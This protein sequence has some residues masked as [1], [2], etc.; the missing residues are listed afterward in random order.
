M[1]YL[2]K[3]FF[4]TAVAVSL[5]VFEQECWATRN[6]NIKRLNMCVIN[7]FDKPIEIG[8]VKSN[9]DLECLSADAVPEEIWAWH[10]DVPVGRAIEF[11]YCSI[12]GASEDS[13][14]VIVPY[15]SDGR[16]KSFKVFYKDFPRGCTEGGL[17]CPVIARGNVIDVVDFTSTS[18]YNVLH[19]YSLLFFVRVGEKEFV[20]NNRVTPKWV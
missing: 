6:L 15:G 13:F 1:K 3:L 14:I 8:V 12:R 5:I 20:I 19:L 16:K 17:G 4:I 2:S 11:R 9:A 7:G 18:A 10:V